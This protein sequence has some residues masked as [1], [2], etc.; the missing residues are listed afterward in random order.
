MNSL[1]IV[2]GRVARALMKHAAMVAPGERAEWVQGMANE[3]DY[4]SSDLYAVQWAVGCIFVTYSERMRAM[5]RSLE[6][7]SRWMLALEMLICFL[8]LTLV[9]LTV[10][11]TGAHGGYT[12]QDWL[13]YCS[14]SVLGPVGLVAAFRSL[15]FAP[16]GMSRAMIAG[17]C[18]LTAWTLAAYILQILTFGQSQLSDWWREF[19]II[20]VLPTLAV[21]HL[22]SINFHR[23]GGSLLA[24]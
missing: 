19:V 7:L 16:G 23:R 8:P 9:F 15:F 1:Q 4:L 12:L 6:P 21:L 11:Q 20:A 2:S 5:V 10:V 17:L 13:L 24:V 18:L 22:V 3:L 14:G